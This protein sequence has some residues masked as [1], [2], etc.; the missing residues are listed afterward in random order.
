MPSVCW[1]KAGRHAAPGSRVI[2]RSARARRLDAGMLVLAIFAGIGLGAV[3]AALRT[4]PFG[5]VVQS[6]RPDRFMDFASHRAFAC[7]AWAGDLVSERST[8]IYTVD[9][10]L[11]AT[12]RW[13][14]F[15]ATI[16]L[17]FGYSPTML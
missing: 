1:R 5:I 11:E 13:S 2:A 7:A 3:I 14:G 4:E 12:A 9:A 10:H 16:A 15:P 6:G 8:S 17:P